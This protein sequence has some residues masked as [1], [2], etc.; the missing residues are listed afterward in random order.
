MPFTLATL[1]NASHGIAIPL[2]SEHSAPPSVNTGF[3]AQRAAWA[4]CRHLP[5]TPSQCDNLGQGVEITN[6]TQVSLS[7]PSVLP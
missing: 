4:A 5:L 6:K 1:P 3:L 7:H 2:L